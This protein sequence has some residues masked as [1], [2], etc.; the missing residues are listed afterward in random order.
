M[1]R[2]ECDE[3]FHNLHRIKWYA[4]IENGRFNNLANEINSHT[5]SELCPAISFVLWII[6]Q[7]YEIPEVLLKIHDSKPE[8]IEAVTDFIDSYFGMV[9]DFRVALMTL[10][11]PTS[12]VIETIE[13][14]YQR[15]EADEKI[16]VGEF[17]DFLRRV[18]SIR[19][20]LF[21]AILETSMQPEEIT[22]YEVTR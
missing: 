11:L 5:Q 21:R 4:F 22:H 13:R 14:E 16:H 6:N 18:I 12:K 9:L 3:V 1:N 2:V 7:M 17:Q 15:L 10:S 20:K 8:Y 19:A